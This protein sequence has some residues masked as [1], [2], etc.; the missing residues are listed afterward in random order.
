MAACPALGYLLGVAVTFVAVRLLKRAANDSF[1]FGGPG[2]VNRMLR[3]GLS[4]W[5][6]YVENHV[7]PPLGLTLVMV[8][9]VLPNEEVARGPN[10][11][12]P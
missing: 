5:F 12:N 2:L 8:A 1:R 7:A 4:P 3:R 10:A 9:T 6:R 11:P